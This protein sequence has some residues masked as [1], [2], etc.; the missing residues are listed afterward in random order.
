MPCWTVAWWRALE[1]RDGV[2]REARRK[3]QKRRKEIEAE[4]WRRRKK[5][6]V[7]EE[8]AGRREKQRLRGR[9]RDRGG[10]RRKMALAQGALVPWSPDHRACWS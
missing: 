2:R 7:R 6:H 10:E 8:M 9:H 1:G 3:R 4:A 5:D